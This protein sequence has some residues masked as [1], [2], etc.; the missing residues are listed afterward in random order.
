MSEG[1]GEGR[2]P[3]TDRVS[4]VVL[5]LACAWFAFTAFWGLFGIPGDGH[6]GAGSAGNTMAAEQIV[7]WKIPY[8]AFEWYTGVA[9]S[10]ASYICHHPYGQYYVPAFFLWIFGHRD[11][12]VHLPAALMSAA[13]P[14]ML[15]GIARARWGKAAGAVAAAAYT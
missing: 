15:Y 10:K 7:R 3:W 4:R 13:M 9:P 6:I 12:V 1:R 2:V 14:P 8:P 5:V 11:F